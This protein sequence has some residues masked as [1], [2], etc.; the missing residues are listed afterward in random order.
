MF[1]Y[2]TIGLIQLNKEGQQIDYFS[3][4]KWC[5]AGYAELKID[6]L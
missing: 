3:N 1:H 5:T 4:N 6:A 2:R